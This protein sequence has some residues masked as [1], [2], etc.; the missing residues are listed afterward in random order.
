MQASI[1]KGELIKSPPDA[2]TRDQIDEEFNAA[3]TV[4]LDLHRPL[5]F[6]ADEVRKMGFELPKTYGVGVIGMTQHLD[7]ELLDIS[8][9]GISVVDDIP[10]IEP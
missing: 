10:F 6:W 8:V 4:K 1:V 7:M 2:I 5:P 3:E 9:G